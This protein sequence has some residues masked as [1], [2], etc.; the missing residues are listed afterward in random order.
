[1]PTSDGSDKSTDRAE[2]EPPSQATDRKT[3]RR[4][5]VYRVFEDFRAKTTEIRGGNM[6]PR[7]HKSCCFR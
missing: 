4:T 3:R 5:A 2:A 6:M 7:R 1:M